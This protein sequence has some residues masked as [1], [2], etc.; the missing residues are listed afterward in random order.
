MS[1]L[2]QKLYDFF[3][4]LKES[5]DVYGPELLG[6]IKMAAGQTGYMIS[7]VWGSFENIITNG[8][9]YTSL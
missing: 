1:P 4:P 5:W 7:S 9:I 2:A 3:K 6:Q 8:T